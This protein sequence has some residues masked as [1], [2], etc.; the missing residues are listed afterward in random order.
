MSVVRSKYDKES[1]E[2]SV[3]LQPPCMSHKTCL[4][5]IGESDNS[6]GVSSLGSPPTGGTG[7]A[8]FLGDGPTGPLWLT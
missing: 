7:R 5:L 3:R 6:T 8:P 4:R 1:Q 2:G